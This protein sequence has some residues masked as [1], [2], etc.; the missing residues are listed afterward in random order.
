MTKDDRD[1]LIFD[2]WQHES[3][4]MTIGQLMT[5]AGVGYSTVQKRRTPEALKRLHKATIDPQQEEL[6]P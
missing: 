4:Y 2:L 5:L 3:Q 1:E 6:D